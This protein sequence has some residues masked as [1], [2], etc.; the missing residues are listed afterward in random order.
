LTA[1]YSAQAFAQGTPIVHGPGVSL[2]ADIAG[3]PLK[4][5]VWVGG[6]YQLPQTSEGD[7]I[8]V[9]LSTVAFRGGAQAAWRLRAAD[10][11]PP[12]RD[13][14]LGARLGL[15]A[16]LVHVV[17]VR[18]TLDPALTLTSP[19]W[20]STAVVT[21]ALRITTALGERIDV[22]AGP[23]VDVYLTRAHYDVRVGG[24]LSTIVEPLTVRPGLLVGL[25]LR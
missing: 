6:Q 15:G 23:I 18:G 21:A 14:F 19:Y 3:G 11:R 5:S 25:T 24:T 12:F 22:V 13:T 7:G 20:S 2:L 9:E 1:S 10:A 17:P 4:I 16:D 8:G